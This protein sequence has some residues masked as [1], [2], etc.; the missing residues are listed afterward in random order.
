MKQMYRGILREI[1]ANPNKDDQIQVGGTW[2]DIDPSTFDPNMRIR[3]NPALGKGSDMTRLMALQ[4]VRNTQQTIIEKFGL[5]NPIVGVEEIRNTIVDMLELA[6]IKTPTRYFREVTPEIAQQIASTPKE[7]DPAS[8]LAQAELE[9]VKK[10][11]I[12]AKA[13][14]DQKEQQ[15]AMDDDFKRDELN[16]RLFTDMVGI[17]AEFANAEVP[18]DTIE[19]GAALNQPG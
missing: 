8:L 5:N 7:P 19:A 2:V 14:L 4:D 15:Q 9:K 17:L 10:D 16:V 1:V 12:V 18:E 6:N 13:T 11:I 3:V